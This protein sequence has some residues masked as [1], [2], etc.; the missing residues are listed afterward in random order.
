MIESDLLAH[1]YARAA[2]LASF[3]Q[4]E[5]GPGDDCAVIA[6]PESRRILLTVD[7]LVE[8][9]HF[10]RLDPSFTRAPI[11]A[12]ARKAVARSISDIA[13]M[14]GAPTATLA[15]ACLPAGFP[16]A[17]AG[18]LFDRVNH[19]AAHFGSPL[20]GGDIACSA[21][22]TP[23]VLTT[24]VIG[25]PHPM[26]GPVLRSTARPGD[27]VYVTGAL[28][29][30]LAS[31]RHLTFE[32]RLA[33][34]RW[35]AS[36]LGAGL[37][38]MIDLSDGLGLDASRIARASRARLTIQASLVPRHADCPD[39]RHACSDGEDYEL[40][41]TASPGSVITSADR[42][43]VTH[44][45]RVEAGEPGCTI[46]DPQGSPIDGAGMGWVHGTS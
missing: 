41:F 29:G 31:G 32:P 46:V 9:R 42:T 33:E 30:S 40:L 8:G 5:V 14:A 3:P 39:W 28:G 19:W 12:I 24:T 45:G 11:D 34:A 35:L 2:S 38:S 7:Q 23:L 44:I 27:N 6:C 10:E 16:Q 4:V 15:T 1:I 36:N 26:R 37:T 43:P 18:E 25:A 20:V 21:A 17:I 13:A 22:G